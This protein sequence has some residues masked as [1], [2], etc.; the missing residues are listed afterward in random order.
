MREIVVFLALV[1]AIYMSLARQRPQLV[2]KLLPWL[3]LILGLALF[4][5]ITMSS[6]AAVVSSNLIT[7][8]IPIDWL[9]LVAAALWVGG[10]MYIGT[11]FLPILRRLPMP[12]RARSLVTVLP[13]YTPWAIA[14]I[15]IMAVTG[16]FSAT[17]QMNSWGQLF[18]TA[19]GRTLI[20]KIVLVAGLLLTTAIHIFL[21]RPRLKREAKKYAYAVQRLEARQMVAAPKPVTTK[22]VNTEGEAKDS[23][24]TI[25]TD[26]STRAITQQVKLREER[27]TKGTRTMT[28]ILSWEPVLGVAILVCVGLMNVFVATLAPTATTQQPTNKKPA[29]FNTTAKTTDNKFTVKLNVNPNTFGTNVFTATVIDNSTGQPT[30][31]VS[32]S[33]FTTMQDMNMGTDTI[34]LQPD[35]KGHFS[36]PG[37]LSMA[38][39]WEIQIQ[40]RTPDNTRH[41]ANVKLFTPF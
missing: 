26:A 18:T 29:S 33:L 1:V 3:N 11:S 13:Y 6:L 12:E 35:G 22:T 15:V 41:E 27:L 32:V 19:Y 36:A 34:I 20:I 25:E 9:H 16:P 38:G 28:R 37:D 40:I 8:A 39:N 31:K 10:M 24:T 5:A 2:N 21:L 7:L 4:I 30:T 17:L 23:S 14:G